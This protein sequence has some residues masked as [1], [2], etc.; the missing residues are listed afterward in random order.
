MARRKSR[1]PKASKAISKV[2][3]KNF[4]V[5]SNKSYGSG[6]K[7]TKIYYEGK[8][9]SRL[10]DDGSISFGKNILEALGKRFGKKFWWI[11]TQKIDSIDVEY[12]ITRV[13]T[14]EAML[15]RMW[16]KEF[17]RR[18]DVKNDIIQ[19]AFYYAFPNYFTTAPPSSY[20][21][22]SLAKLLNPGI[23][24]K[25]S[26]E[27]KEAMTKFLPHFISSESISSIN[28]L[29]ASAQIE[30]L[31]ELAAELEKE[32]ANTHAE[33]WWQDYIKGKILIIQQG[34]IR[35]IEK[36]NVAI[37]NTKFP[38][39]ALVTHDNYLDILEIKKPNT[40]ILKFDA[41]RSNYF[42]DA[43]ISRAII[44]VE[45]YLSNLERHGSDVRGFI[46][47]TYKIDLKVV[48]PRGIILA[49]DAR[50]LT[51]QKQRD[52]FR[53]LSHGLKHITIVTYDELLTRLRNYIGVLEQFTTSK[54]AETLQPEAT[55]QPAD[56][57]TEQPV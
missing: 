49:G 20:H 45:N 34:Y 46:K 32:I 9:P 16:A 7:G 29:K 17:E 37:G 51:E 15:K 2:D 44:Q 25:L 38:D 57:E 36:M 35:A 23:L 6:L 26:S 14:S 43:E 10:R 52:D 1:A 4:V 39:F 50:G 5:V 22:G 40:D 41:G 56:V 21:S 27:D 28:L 55:G 48:R 12:G 11:I 33:S 31:K 42:F 3:K 13:R 30:S 47:D 24:K 18:R 19:S 54:P 53:L 8:R